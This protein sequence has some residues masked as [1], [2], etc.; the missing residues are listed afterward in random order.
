MNK[1]PLTLM[2]FFLASAFATAAESTGRA[3]VDRE[4]LELFPPSVAVVPEAKQ[5]QTTISSDYSPS[6]SLWTEAPGLD[7]RRVFDLLIRHEQDEDNS[8]DMRIGKG[9]QIYSLR[10][11][12]GESINPQK[13]EAN[14]NDGVWQP[15]CHPTTTKYHPISRLP[16]EMAKPIKESEYAHGQFIHGAGTYVLHGMDSGDFTVSCDVMLHPDKPGPLSILLR[17][18][19]HGRPMLTFGTLSISE[20]HIDLNGNRFAEARPGEWQQIKLAFSLNDDAEGIVT[21]SVRNADESNSSATAPF[22][23]S[24]V[25]TFTWLGLSAAG[26]GEGVTYV[27]NLEAKRVEKGQT[28]WPLQYDFEQASTIS[29]D[30][31]KFVVGADEAKDARILV[32]DRVAAS[33]KR[34]LEIRD[35]AGLEAGWQPLMRMHL[36]S[37]LEGSLYSPKLASDITGNGRIFRTANWG[38][39]PQLKTISRSPILYYTQLRDVGDGIIEVTY[40]FHNFNVRDDI[41]YGH[42]NAPWGSTRFSSL[43]HFY[44]NSPDGE[45][46]TYGEFKGAWND[47][48]T[49]DNLPSAGVIDVRKTGGWN[50]NSASEADDAPSLALVFGRDR[51][52]EAEQERAKKGLPFAQFRESAFRFGIYPRPDDW[53]TRPE[54][55]W[56]NWY[57]QALLPKLHLTQG[58]TVWYRYFF[59]I[60]RKD[61]AIE[62]AD[63][64]VDKVDYGLLTFDA[65]DTPQVPV[66]VSGG[67]VVDGKVSRP[68]KDVGRETFPAIKLFAHPVSGTMPLFLIENASTG[69]EVVTTDPY[70]FV[71]QEKMNYEVPADPKF[72][73]YRNAVG[74]DMRVDK[75]NSRWKRLLGYGYV[76]KPEA[77]DFV[78]L[79]QLLNAELFPK[80]N[81][82]PAAGQAYH[83][84]LWVGF[85]GEGVFHEE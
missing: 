81:T 43:P 44:V 12:F 47:P 31:E 48:A 8:F 37:T 76:E 74:Y 19:E 56:E 40:I 57:G 52:L 70:I 59:V 67:K 55:S 27:D 17:D 80:A 69:Q 54:N 28:E 22:S 77:G 39:V 73:N 21:A 33:G 15:V 65:A 32:T 7:E 1:C 6:G 63:S 45:L 72:D 51:H 14:W 68:T 35:A 58:K 26:S 66:Y 18:A 85:S 75:N 49:V 34:S 5:G 53:Q 16:E 83:L 60:N 10:G 82:P 79:S 42:M 29:R 20:R 36:H 4:L 62:L 38:L 71:P 46:M 2:V 50:L 23:A 24:G 3:A 9:G 11:S 64:L 30:L 41:D 78:R 13:L 84:D 61:R 25:R